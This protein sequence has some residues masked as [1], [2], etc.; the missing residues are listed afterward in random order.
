MGGGNVLVKE[1]CLKWWE[2]MVL[3]EGSA[4]VARKT[5]G[6]HSKVLSVADH[7]SLASA[8]SLYCWKHVQGTTLHMLEI[9]L[10][11]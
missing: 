2:P 11:G 3:F 9:C 10:G 5:A 7:R 1:S 8:Y 4:H 6:L